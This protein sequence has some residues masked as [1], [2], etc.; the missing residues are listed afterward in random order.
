M[1]FLLRYSVVGVVACLFP[2]EI[3]GTAPIAKATSDSQPRRASSIAVVGSINADTFLHV[4][5]LPVAGENVVTT[6]GSASMLQDVP[7]GKGA[8]QAIAACRLGETVRFVAQWGADLPATLRSALNDVD[9][10]D[11]HFCKEHKQIPTG[12]GFVLCE[13]ST[14]E[15]S[16]VVYGGANALGW[17]GSTPLEW[18]V[19]L[20]DSVRLCML[21]REIPDSVNLQVA[22]YC[23]EHNIL[24][25]QDA[26]GRDEPISSE[27]L[28]LVDYIIPNESELARLVGDD[29][30]HGTMGDL[31][32]D[33]VLEQARRLQVMGANHVLVT[34][35]SKGCLLLTD[36]GDVIRHPAI[37]VAQVLDETG[38][39]DC[40]RAAFGVRLLETSNVT[41]ALLFAAAA[42][43]CAVQQTGAIPSVPTRQEVWGMLRG[44]CVGKPSRNGRVEMIRGGATTEQSEQF[45]LL[46][47]SR[48]N[49]MKDRPELW[50]GPLSTPRDFLARQARVKGLTC[51]D[52]NFPQHFG[53][54]WTPLE[55][56]RALDDHGLVGGAV[57]LRYPK[58]FARG[59]MNHPDPT[60]R[61]MAIEI[62]KEAAEAADILGCKEV[63]VWSAYDGYDYPFQVDYDEKWQQLIEAF[64][65]CCD[66]F[67]HIKFSVEYKPTDENTRFFTI[68]STAASLLLANEVDRPNFGL[69]LD[70]GHMLMSGENPGQSIA[71]ATRAERLF[72]VQLND[73]FTRLAAEDGLMFGSVHPN[74]ALEVIYQ[75]RKS[76]F[77]GHLY[78][79][80]FPQ[81]T[82]PIAEAEYNIRRVK[83]F[84]KAAGSLLGAKRDLVRNA[85]LEHDA[86]GALNIVDDALRGM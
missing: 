72:G 55:A 24:V 63:V 7:G 6:G 38:A 61:R 30:P 73:G 41:E 46:I 52:F 70:V 58:E 62:T 47:G 17:D 77:A 81:R 21:Q 64:Q 71:M 36:E 2:L 54:W 5:R 20:G 28:G 53:S 65:E 44:G 74:I 33:Q 67:P 45:P 22:R 59:A 86:I 83:S 11:I 14:G 60:M 9:A 69:T 19:V 39:G 82:D 84:W 42:G 18:D 51:V 37:P 75:L 48:L 25:L 27:L 31:S 13:T 78:F 40:F 43:A 66:A 57:C 23:R 16:A 4:D 50:D 10:L 76:N 1:M 68:P 12:R 85:A 8:T 32:D 3:S 15:V 80:T 34:L 35:G 79:D 49:S 26:G 29:P 56:R